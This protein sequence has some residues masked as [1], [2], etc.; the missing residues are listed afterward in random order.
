M[1][2]LYL[3]LKNYATIYTAMGRKEIEIDFSKS[4]NDVILFVGSNGSGKTSLLSTLH[5]FPYYGSMDQRNNT[6][7]IREGHDGYKEIWIQNDDIIY[8]IQHYYKNSKR[9]ITLKSF[10]QKNDVEL[11]PN[12][13]VTSFND[14]VKNELSLELD[15]LRLL[16]LGSNVTNLIDMKA[17]ERKNFTSYLLSDI[18]IYNDLFKKVNDDNRALKSM[19]KSVSDKL[20]RLNV[21][22]KSVLES[23]INKSEKNL[24]EYTDK[25]NDLQIQLGENDGKIKT[26][27]P[28][29]IEVLNQ[30][31]KDLEKEKEDLLF[32]IKTLSRNIEKLCIILTYP[33]EKEIELSEKQLRDLESKKTVNDNMMLFFK[34]QLNP[35]YNKQD[36]I[37][38]KIS[39]SVSDVAYHQIHHLYM[40]ISDKVKNLD[41][42]YK[43]YTP[44]YTKDNLI[45]LLEVLK[46]IDN[47]ANETYGFDMRAVKQTVQMIRNGENVDKYIIDRKK[48]ID[49]EILKLTSDFKNS[50]N[51]KSPVILFKPS[52]C[53]EKDCPYLFLYDLLFGE[54]K[55]EGQSLSSLEHEKD[56]LEIIDNIHKN[57]DYI[58]MILKTNMSLISKGD[59]SYF[60]ID[61]ILSS[62]ENGSS[63]YNEDYITDLISEAEEYEEYCSMKLQMKELQAELKT[64]N[65]NKNST[66]SLKEELIEL[67][68]SI[69]EI[70]NKENKVKTDNE[71]LEE[72]I[73]DLQEYI[74]HLNKYKDYQTKLIE[75]KDKITSIDN[76]LIRIKTIINSVSEYLTRSDIIK[77]DIS[78]VDW[79]I[80]KINKEIFNLKVKLQEFNSL[81]REQEIL[82]TKF[83][84]INLIKESLSSTKGIPLLYMQL[85]LKNTKM[86]VNELLQTVYSDNFQIDDFE[87]TESEFNIPYIKN[88][89]RI[90]DVTYASQGEKSFLSLA[91]S[92]ALINQSIKNYNILLLDEIDSTLDTK[93]RAMFLNILEKQMSSISAEQVF[94]ITHNNM[95]ENYPVDV[96]LTSDNKVTNFSNAN[97]IFSV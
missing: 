31:Y 34:E 64:L 32:D 27:V 94:L 23:D 80:D 53:P 21:I 39:V 19:I 87:I 81:T 7:I 49:K 20:I 60:R 22:D 92:F 89:T 18:N 37:N 17:A 15:F 50:L 13:N 63:V 6:D 40:D 55:T 67:E 4:K 84:D 45:N 83:D 1:K 88:N 38:N 68:K 95:F 75:D 9:G 71:Q 96:I 26:L 41:K 90:S 24:K 69:A 5:P 8:K 42:K 86:F 25:K 2:I 3:K 91:L 61:S 72:D 14:V 12:G 82:N 78:I 58:L 30:S 29:G 52:N 44:V 51:P 66:E 35:L 57:I 79:E 33:I 16:R 46:Q 11:N 28:E 56:L 70:L 85:Y 97:I 43:D 77:K 93:N 65:S 62:M 10:I 59:I 54:N 36:D 73:E 76:E 47:V 74:N 48:E